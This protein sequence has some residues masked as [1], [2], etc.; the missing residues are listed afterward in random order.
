MIRRV[1]ARSPYAELLAYSRVV[2][3]GDEAWVSGCAPLDADG[4]LIGPDLPGLQAGACINH[5]REALEEAGFRLSDV[6]RL[7]IHVK[8][9]EHIDDIARAQREAFKGIDPACSVIAANFV[10]PDVLVYMD[11]D[12]KRARAQP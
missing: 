4:T 3:I 11:A 8:S 7:R 12:A 1:P 9:F 10:T 2:A 5:I 6:V